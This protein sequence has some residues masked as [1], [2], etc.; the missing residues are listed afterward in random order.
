MTSKG[1]V[2]LNYLC[3]LSKQ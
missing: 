1:F 2:N 3:C